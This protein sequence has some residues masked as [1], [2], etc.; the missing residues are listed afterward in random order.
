MQ[1]KMK[2]WL[3]V[4]GICIVLSAVLF[5]EKDLVSAK[6]IQQDK[7]AEFYLEE[8]EITKNTE[9][10]YFSE[11]GINYVVNEDGT[12]SDEM[13][14]LKYTYDT[15]NG[16]Y[17]VSVQWGGTKHIVIADTLKGKKVTTI[18]SMNSTDIETVKLGKYVKKIED[19]TFYYLRSLKKVVLSDAVTTIG[20]EA[21]AYSGLESI[22][23][24]KNVKSIGESAFSY[25][26]NLINVEIKSEKLTKIPKKCFHYAEK[27]KK[28]TLPEKVTSLG[29]GAFS[30]CSALEKVVINGNVKTIPA[31]CFQATVALKSIKFPSA[32]TKINEYAFSYSGLEKVTIPEKVTKIG[33]W[34][35]YGCKLKTLTIKGSLKELPYGAFADCTVLEQVKISGKIKT[36]RSAFSGCSALEQVDITGT[37]TTMEGSVFSNCPSLKQVN[38]SGSV[39]TINAFVFNGCT[40]LEKVK[41]SGKVNKINNS[42]FYNCKKLTQVVCSKKVK[43]IDTNAFEECNSCL[44]VVA[45]KESNVYRTLYEGNQVFVTDSEEIEFNLNTGLMIV[46]ESK[47]ITA[48]N[49][50]GKLK[51]KSSNSSVIKISSTG[52][53]TA[54]KA[55]K[56]TLTATCGNQKF[57]LKMQVLDRTKENVMRVIYAEYVRPELSDYEKVVQANKW[58]VQ[59]VKYDY[60]NYLNGTIPWESYTADGAFVNGLA[61]CNGYA[62][63][64][65]E[66]MNH[67]E[68]PCVK[69][70][71]WAMNHAWNAV[72][73]KGHWYHVD[74]TWNDPIV[75]GSMENTNVYTNYL[76]VSDNEFE[77]HYAYDFSCTTSKRSKVN[78]TYKTASTA[79]N[80]SVT[81]KSPV[82]PYLNAIST[83]L[84][85]GGDGF[86]LEITGTKAKKFTSSNKKV[87]TVTSK[88]VIKAKKAGTATIKV[89]GA[90]GKTY[91]CKVT[92][93]NP[94]INKKKLSL[95]VGKSY[96]LKI[97]NTKQ[98]VQWMTSDSNIA[99]VTS[100]GKVKAVGAGKVKI[101]A[102]VSGKKFTCTV[103]VHA[104]SYN[105]KVIVAATC[106]TSGVKQYTCSCGKRY[107]EEI[108]SLGH[109]YHWIITKEASKTEAKS[110]DDFGT[111]DLTCENCKDVKQTQSIINMGTRTIYGYFDDESADAFRDRIN[112]YRR[113]EVYESHYAYND[114]WISLP[115]LK[116]AEN[117]VSLVKFETVKYTV[118]REKSGIWEDRAELIGAYS[119]ET[120]DTVWRMRFARKGLV[121][122]EVTTQIGTCC[123][124]LDSNAD[125]ETD[126]VFWAVVVD[127]IE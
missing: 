101:T 35:F 56:V 83:T 100:K 22:V 126:N 72:Q 45:P 107:T 43:E 38:I 85:V 89:K 42:A 115:E 61:V 24:T 58:L 112:K 14:G 60:E 19:Q 23:L 116:E 64:F 80:T 70:T 33:Q 96:T 114:T 65:Q 44:T 91:S 62:L 110:V 13:Q 10:K 86:K 25:C 21:F 75:N 103:T 28:I 98:K 99:T 11:N 119:D 39:G 29:T 34:A 6:E 15:K 105:A 3:R 102:E 108:G 66:I 50:P 69:V 82:N 122:R 120:L 4:F 113:E 118:T 125:G 68:I 2:K 8:A 63:A 9:T 52:E 55:G 81:E 78:R 59:N 67:Y 93:E 88:G 117:L 74:V 49:Y 16:T 124:H 92:V 54:K 32:L 48:Y 57:T 77:G 46:G 111:R 41:I 123:F 5:G 7:N 20:K 30:Y 127:R 12:I 84:A 51:W 47:H 31:E 73:I 94:K 40:S 97:S 95:E 27:L 17:T 26:Y 76:L 79:A 53:A 36:M 71:S 104:H 87:A 106:T 109:D 121:R 90:D 18:T 1:N 37:V